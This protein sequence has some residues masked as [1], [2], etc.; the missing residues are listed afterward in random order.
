M[1][2]D[3]ETRIKGHRG[4]D[5]HQ[6]DSQRHLK[7]NVSSKVLVILL[8]DSSTSVRKD[9][10]VLYMSLGNKQN[11]GSQQSKCVHGSNSVYSFF[12]FTK[13]RDTYLSSAVLRQ[14]RRRK[15]S[16]DR[17]IFISRVVIFLCWERRII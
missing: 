16:P 17:F 6:L 12:L 14:K 7:R 13:L 1:I 9:S 3:R 15:T 2:G 5:E 11:D 4:S 10:G 8:C